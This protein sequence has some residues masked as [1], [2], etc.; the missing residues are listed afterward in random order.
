MSKIDYQPPADLSGLGTAAFEDTGTS[1]HTL[2]FLDGANT[3]S[4]QNIFAAGTLTASAPT[5][6]T[7]TWNNA[8]V[9]FKGLSVSITDTASAAGAI[10]FEVL[11]GASGTDYLLYLSKVGGMFLAG[12]LS[13]GG[14]FGTLD[15]A[16]VLI[17]GGVY[18][19][20]G[21]N[22]YS[23]N[24]FGL[25]RWSS[26][27]SF[28]T[29]GPFDT[30]LQRDDAGI[31][32]QVSGTQEQAKRIYRTWTDASNYERQALQSGSGY[33]EWAAETAGSGT[34]DIS[35]RLTPAGAGSVQ[36]TKGHFLFNT[37]NTYDIGASGATRPRDIYLGG[38][39]AAVGDAAA[40]RE[41]LGLDVAPE[42]PG[43]RLTLTSDTPVLTTDTTGATSIYYTPFRDAGIPIY[44]G[45]RWARK[46]FSELTMTL[47]T[48]NQLAEKLYDLFVWNDSGT[49]KIGAG[50]AWV[51]AATITVTI[52]TPA[53]V[54]FTAHGLYEGAPIIFTTTGA[55]PTGI[56]AGTTYYVGRSPAA[57]TF[58]ISTSVANA[59]AG[60][61][62]NTSGTQSG[63][64]TGTN[65][66]TKRGT[67]AGTTELQKLAGI[68]TNKNS[69]TLTN[70]AGGGTS[71][72][73]ANTATYV[74]TFYTTANGQTGMAFKPAA[75]AGGANPILGLFN[76]YN[77]VPISSFTQE[78]N[79]GWTYST[80]TWRSP[81]AAANMRVNYV[82]GLS[83][84]SVRASYQV[85]SWTTTNTG[86]RNFNGI[87]RD[88]TTAAPAIQSQI[89]NAGTANHLMWVNVDES[90]QPSLG[91][92]YLQ[93]VEKGNGTT[94]SNWAA[95]TLQAQL[96]M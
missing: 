4:A 22:H 58:N 51:N 32:A 25:I 23:N 86:A 93:P 30:I 14:G 37:D 72:I 60:T 79:S 11:G 49:L 3:W 69:I 95:G 10:P 19:H 44:D 73:A 80:N 27:A 57:N 55:L 45:T 16:A 36:L 84:L 2:P 67:G 41:A 43:G 82:D 76:A 64:H 63:T 15:T 94:T 26:S 39:I 53:V 75:A 8:S 35:L 52:A 77:Q 24:K 56:T 18:G 71:G 89:A 74:G 20:L 33:F 34:D 70:G 59:I 38:K 65:A 31:V 12:S 13:L 5:Q 46:L 47:N 40:S 83:H 7:Q 87:V 68:W 50:P 78:T 96:Q 61:F 62:I 48:S 6:F 29:V 54:T 28:A 81:N 21:I 1:G 90:F 85:I 42:T 9:A 17:G 88:N 91:M 66:T 92:H